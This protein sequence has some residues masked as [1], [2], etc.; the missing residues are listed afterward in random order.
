M[1]AF[2]VRIVI[3]SVVPALGG[4]RLGSTGAKENWHRNGFLAQAV[5]PPRT[6]SATDPRA[7]VRFPITPIVFEPPIAC[8]AALNTGPKAKASKPEPA[9]VAGLHLG[10]NRDEVIAVFCAR[11]KPTIREQHAAL[12]RNGQVVAGIVGNRLQLLEEPYLAGITCA[13]REGQ[14]EVKFAPPPAQ[15]RVIEVIHKAYGEA[16]GETPT[17]YSAGLLARY[18]EPDAHSGRR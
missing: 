2:A 9:D 6:S 4:A 12:N 14:S 7:V 16:L 17:A 5:D 8:P 10:M 1:D 11:T 18:G 15:S 13:T 3:L